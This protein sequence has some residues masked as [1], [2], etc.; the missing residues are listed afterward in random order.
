MTLFILDNSAVGMTGGQKSAAEGRIEDIVKGLGVDP[1]H[2]RIVNPIPKEHQ[3]MVQVF[4]EEIAYPGLSVII[5]R[6]E[7]VQTYIRRIKMQKKAK[8]AK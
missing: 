6:R 2:I 7:C 3:T 1:D 4:S 8:A 5:P